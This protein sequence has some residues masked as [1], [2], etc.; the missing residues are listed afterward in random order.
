MTKIMEFVISI[1]NLDH[2][3]GKSQL[4]KQVL[5]NINLEI[6]AGEIIILLSFF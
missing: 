6:N 2:Y 1:E 3:F 4:K 5:F